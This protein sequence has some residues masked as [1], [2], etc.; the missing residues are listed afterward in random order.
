MARRHAA[1]FGVALL[2]LLLLLAIWPQVAAGQDQG[3]DQANG[4]DESDAGSPRLFLPLASSGG[5]AQAAPD[6][7]VWSDVVLPA[8]VDSAQRWVEPDTFRLVSANMGRLDTALAQAPAETQAGVAAASS[9]TGG[10]TVLELPLPNGTMQ[11]FA[12]V[13]SPIMAPELAAQYPEIKTYEARGIDDPTAVARLDRTPAGFHAM[14][15]SGGDTVFID[16]YLRGSDALYASYYR[17][18]YGNHYGKTLQELGPLTG[19]SAGEATADIQAAR[20][21]PTM[22]TY[23]LALAATGEYTQFYDDGNAANGNAVA[24]A[25]AGMTTT[26]NRVNALYRRD[27]T[28]QFTLIGN[29]NLLVYTDP[30]TDPYTN[31]DG[32]TMEGENQSNVDSVIGNGNYDIGLVFSTGGGG[33]AGLGVV[34]NNSVKARGVTGSGAPVGDPFDV[35]YV[36]HEMGHQFGGNHT[37]NST[38]S[39]CGG[40]NRNGGTAWEPGSGST[41]MAY[42]GICGGQNLQPNSDDH[43]HAGSIGE[44]N[45]FVTTGG[46]SSCGTTAATGNGMPTASAGPGF[47]IPRQTPFTLTGSGTDPNGDTLTFNWE[48]MDIGGAWTNDGVLPNTDADGSAR[49]IFRTQRPGADTTRTFPTLNSILDGTNSN[50]GESLPSIDRTMQFRL[51]AR[52]GRGGVNDA[53]MSVTVEN[54][55]GPFAVTAPN[56]AATWAVDTNQNVTWD[57]A[58]TTAAPVSCANVNIL[59]STDGGQTFPITLAANTP[60]DGSQAITVPANETTTGRVKVACAGNIFFDIDNANFTILRVADLEIT[61]SDAPDPVVAGT[62]LTYQLNVTNHGPSNALS[63]AVVDTLP[64][65]VTLAS[66]T[67]SQGSCS[68]TTTVT[69][70][71]GSLANGASA[72]VTIVV[73]VDPALVHNAGAPTTITN[74]AGVSSPASDPNPGNNNASA[75]TRVIAQADL[76]ILSFDAVAPPEQIIVGQDVPLLLRK[77]ITNYGP[78][79][80]MDAL[81]T[82]TGTGP[83]DTVVTPPT[84]TSQAL[85]V[86]LNEQRTVDESFTVR[87]NGASHHL[88]TFT[89]EIQPLR[90]DDT[91]P[92]QANNKARVDV[93]IECVVPV[94]INIKPGSF[95]NSINTQD[96]GVVPVGILTTKAGEYGKPLAFD[97]TSIDP[98][99]V[100]FGPRACV[101]AD[102]CGAFEAHKRGHIEDVVEL[103]EKTKDR[104]KDM[105]LHFTTLETGITPGMGE[106]CVKG[107]WLD[108][109]GGRHT[110]FG[111]DS[112]RPVK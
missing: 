19:P 26:M 23:R 13:E 11:R 55:A 80:P 43:F 85:A 106:A 92:N 69:C 104:D 41:I 53:T 24:D 17:S 27:L 90:P 101:W 83:A 68:G 93:D 57:V 65:G 64:A 36:A 6:T 103:D 21:G 72:A 42:A 108:A 16:P 76:A 77:L 20:S 46:G 74:N 58:N 7:S 18:D 62:A 75:A 15:L 99:S 111:C 78:S 34:C 86:G 82:R 97:A 84:A 30:N 37:Y 96:K 102:E 31:N 105:V 94:T 56:S 35:D 71:I 91:D 67:P 87:C 61:K 14:I 110:F 33:I 88:F 98:L 5:Q 79:A 51:T 52:D 12:V 2:V 54:D 89:N 70:A 49:A 81:L 100:R 39:N 44:I 38:E 8:G 66:A 45:A 22:R 109:A 107:T 40:G 73:N 1:N 60:N 10:E 50:S 3:Q 25:L 9:S 48:E 4:Q 29:T 47:T 63:V 32:A 112:I 95:P 28:I 59:L